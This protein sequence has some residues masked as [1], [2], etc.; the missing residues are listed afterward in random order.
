MVL[1]CLSCCGAALAGQ[2]ALVFENAWVRAMPPGMKMT[3]GF[4]VL[5]NRGSSPIELTGFSSPQ[6]GRVSL[7]RSETVDGVSRMREVAT[8]RVGPGESVELTPGG[9]HLM[10]M[11]PGPNR[12]QAGSVTVLMHAGDG[13]DF[14]FD[15][16]VERR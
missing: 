8:L 1:A 10:L 12:A 14:R 16:P 11:A 13:R 3:A 7:H 15:L 6:F 4:G 5:R 9:Y 2:Q